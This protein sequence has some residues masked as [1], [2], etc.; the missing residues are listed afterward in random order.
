MMYLCTMIGDPESVLIEDFEIHDDRIAFV[1]L[2]LY[3][4][5]HELLHCEENENPVDIERMMRD[6]LRDVNYLTEKMKISHV[7]ISLKNIYKVS[8]KDGFTVGDWA[9]KIPF[10]DYVGSFDSLPECDGASKSGDTEEI[11]NLGL[12]ILEVCGVKRSE[13]EEFI[14]INENEAYQTALEKAVAGLRLPVTTKHAILKILER[15]PNTKEKLKSLLQELGNTTAVISNEHYSKNGSPSN[16]V[17]PADEQEKSLKSDRRVENVNS[18]RFIETSK[19]GEHIPEKSEEDIDKILAGTDGFKIN[20]LTSESF[21]AD[22]SSLKGTRAANHGDDLTISKEFSFRNR[23]S[24]QPLRISFSRLCNHAVPDE[25]IEHI[26]AINDASGGNSRGWHQTSNK[27][28]DSQL[29]SLVLSTILELSEKICNL[30]FSTTPA[31][32]FNQMKEELLNYRIK[33]QERQ[34]SPD[35]QNSELGIQSEHEKKLLSQRG[36]FEDKIRVKMQ[37]LEKIQNLI[38]NKLCDSLKGQKIRSSIDESIGNEYNGAVAISKADTSS[39]ITLIDLPKLKNLTELRQ[40]STSISPDRAQQ[41]DKC[42][43]A[44]ADNENPK[45]NKPRNDSPNSLEKSLSACQRAEFSENEQPALKYS[46]ESR[47]ISRRPKSI[48][49]ELPGSEKSGNMQSVARIS[50]KARVKSVSDASPQL[51]F[52]KRGNNVPGSTRNLILD[53]LTGS[54]FKSFSMEPLTF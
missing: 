30:K 26:A 6:V 54:N 22:I 44:S 45:Q 12:A 37:I 4:L 17:A 27:R 36:N 38:H 7:D 50:H 28:D 34:S 42:I 20:E 25:N 52:Y 41:E 23:E 24:Q 5:R 11:Y 9:S 33:I 1:T 10:V 13:I 29:L 8:E 46:A 40:E 2:P 16:K 48:H 18:P 31:V 43:H 14:E 39:S 51:E 32:D 53:H 3:S 35:Y 21:G 47:R 19:T 15:A 49:T